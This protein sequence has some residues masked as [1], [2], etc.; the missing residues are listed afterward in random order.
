MSNHFI[1]L[2]Q[3]KDLIGRFQLQK[4]NV[5][6]PELR[7][8]G[9]LFTSESFDRACFDEVLAEAN[10]AG[11]RFYLGMNEK[12]ETRLIAVATDA[13]GNDILPAGN[14]AKVSAPDPKIIEEGTRCPHNCPGGFTLA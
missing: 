8:Q 6:V 13:E 1:S 12:L 3:A 5:L 14:A 7:G 4:D 9:I 2:A 11:L 10:A